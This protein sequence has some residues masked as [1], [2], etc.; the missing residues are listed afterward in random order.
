MGTQARLLLKLSLLIGGVAL[1]PLAGG[2]G[3]KR[4]VNK[5]TPR[6]PWQSPTIHSMRSL[7]LI[8]ADELRVV[9]V[10]GCEGAP[11]DHRYAK[12]RR[13]FCIIFAH[14]KGHD[15]RPTLSRNTAQSR[16]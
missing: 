9:L 7:L 4:L 14:V 8:N 13:G 16:N 15:G 6:S 2:C 10:D 1:L 3:S 11:T 5:C 12:I